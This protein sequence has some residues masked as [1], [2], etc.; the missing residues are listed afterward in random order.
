MTT[1][2]L[3]FIQTIKEQIAI[4]KYLLSTNAAS[5]I[6]DCVRA[7]S[8]HHLKGNKK[9]YCF[10]GKKNVCADETE[11]NSTSAKPKQQVRGT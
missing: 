9:E 7:H 8:G 1:D 4:R 10:L 2:N 5:K 6:M 3:W 11:N